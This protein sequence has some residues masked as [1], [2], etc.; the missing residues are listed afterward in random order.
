[1]LGPMNSAIEWHDSELLEINVPSTR[2]GELILDAYV[3]RRAQ[4][5]SEAAGEGG[6]QQIKITLSSMQSVHPAPELPL[7]IQDGVIVLGG[8][9]H[10]GLLPLPMSFDGTV[11]LNLLPRDDAAVLLFTGT[12]IK[13]EA[14][15]DFRFVERLDFG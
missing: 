7:L 5:S 11:T 13:V 15:G 8:E 6:Y 4:E 2:E 3:H 10:R 12:G 14:K 9:E 1:M